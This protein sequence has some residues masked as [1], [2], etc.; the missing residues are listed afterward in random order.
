MGKL[1]EGGG[2]EEGMIKIIQALYKNSTNE[3]RAH[4]NEPTEFIT[5][6]GPKQVHY[7]FQYC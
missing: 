2:T 1:K 7:Y 4:N 3:V 6:I 5:K